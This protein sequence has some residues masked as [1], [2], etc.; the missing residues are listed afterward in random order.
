MRTKISK[1]WIWT[2]LSALTLLGGIWIVAFRRSA[3]ERVFE[4]A[5]STLNDNYYDATMNDLD[6]AGVGRVFKRRAREQ[7]PGGDLYGDTLFPMISLLDGSHLGITRPANAPFGTTGQ[8][9]GIIEP[10]VGACMGM[11]MDAG[12]SFRLPRIVAV[13]VSSPLRSIG[14]EKGW[15]LSDYRPVSLKPDVPLPLV[16]LLDRTGQPHTLVLDKTQAFAGSELP[17]LQ[18]KLMTDVGGVPS[19]QAAINIGKWGIT[20]IP[21]RA[22]GGPFI[23]A[24]WADGPAA[25][26]G[27]KKGDSIRSFGI[28]RTDNSAILRLRMTLQKTAGNTTKIDGTFRCDVKRD[29]EAEFKRVKNTLY[30]RFDRFNNDSARLI[31]GL[32]NERPAKIVLDLRANSGGSSLALRQIAGVFMPPTALLGTAKRRSETEKVY[33]VAS[34]SIVPGEIS[35]LTSNSTA[36]SGE[37]LAASLRRYRNATIFGDR[38]AGHVLESRNWP[39]PDGG[40]IQVPVADFVDADGKRLEGI[41]VMPDKSLEQEPALAGSVSPVAI[42]L[43]RRLQ[44]AAVSRPA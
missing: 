12:T 4:A 42:A 31:T 35:V 36:S 1:F 14:V 15:R 13:A 32:M 38:T 24:V 39:L 18:E 27:I 33:P 20:V 9:S 28:S 2:I 26:M 22:P 44:S 5:W 41:G 16:I 7:R 25:R 37:V 10:T 17:K 43:P 23:S 21:G 34:P 11:V 30:I 40:I 6:W 19:A 8:H 3:E 29:A